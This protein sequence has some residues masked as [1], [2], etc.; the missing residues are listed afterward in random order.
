MEIQHDALSSNTSNDSWFSR[1]KN[2]SKIDLHCLPT[3]VLIGVALLC[4]VGLILLFVFS[5]SWSNKTINHDLI[6][7]II[8]DPTCN[9]ERT[10]PG[11]LLSFSSQQTGAISKLNTKLVVAKDVDLLGI[12]TSTLQW[13]GIMWR[14]RIFLKK[15]ISSSH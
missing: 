9:F 7:V 13:L 6:R 8:N 15:Y 1:R 11:N 4:F 2:S 3:L 10:C 5:R 12:A 14:P